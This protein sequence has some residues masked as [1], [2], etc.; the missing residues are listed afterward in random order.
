MFRILRGRSMTKSRITIT[1]FDRERR[2]GLFR[3]V[4]SR[5]SVKSDLVRTGVH[6]T[7]LIFKNC[8]YAQREFILQSM[9]SYRGGK[10]PT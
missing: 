7:W 2:L 9:R 1:D 8:L 6:K 4:F 5:A 3:D 10:R